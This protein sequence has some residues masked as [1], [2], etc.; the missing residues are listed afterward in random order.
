MLEELRLASDTL[1]TAPVTVTRQQTGAVRYSYVPVGSTTPQRYRC[2]PDL[3][4]A[5][6][7]DGGV[8]A[9]TQQRLIPS[10]T[11]TR[12]GDPGY[13]QLS[14]HSAEEIRRGAEDGSEMGVFH[15]LHQAQ[16][17]AAL[18]VTVE[19]FLPAGLEAG[20]FYMT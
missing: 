8:R 19:E 10:F 12:Y 20:V 5:S 16:R 2:Q 15:H 18:R 6:Q 3:A 13:A 14:P 17:D 11:S 9:R 4:L 7:E 1:F